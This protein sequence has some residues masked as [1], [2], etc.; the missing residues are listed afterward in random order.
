[1]I[2]GVMCIERSAW[3]SWPLLTTSLSRSENSSRNR[4]RR[5]GIVRHRRAM[6]NPQCPSDEAQGSYCLRAVGPRTEHP[7]R[8]IDEALYPY[9]AGNRCAL[10]SLDTDR[11]T[12][13]SPE[14]VTANVYLQQ[15]AEISQ[16]SASFRRRNFA[17][18]LLQP[19]DRRILLKSDL[20]AAVACSASDRCALRA[21]LRLLR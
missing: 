13:L 18:K 19:D 4:E 11:S 20:G 10:N 12:T 8:P 1:M 2:I 17:C 3:P 14:T 6:R 9:R 5:R 21:V 15:R 7:F 16:P